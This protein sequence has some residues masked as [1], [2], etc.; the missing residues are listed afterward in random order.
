MRPA[1]PWRS[2]RSQPHRRHTTRVPVA[3]VQ[4]VR[5]PALSCRPPAGIPVR[6]R[7]WAEPSRQRRLPS[8]LR[9]RGLA[10]KRSRSLA[11]LPP[12]QSG[13]RPIRNRPAKH[14]RARI[15]SLPVEESARIGQRAVLTTARACRWCIRDELVWGS[16]HSAKANVARADRSQHGEV[17]LTSADQ[18]SEEPTPP[19]SESR[20]RVFATCRRVGESRPDPRE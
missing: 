6:L 2:V 14:C 12:L 4:G 7:G 10:P 9:Q 1:D 8:L 20:I 18:L 13:P 16:R 11:A 17:R 3:P 19:P 5:T 15:W